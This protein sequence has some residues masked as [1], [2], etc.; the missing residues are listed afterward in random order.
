MKSY[1]E[2]EVKARGV[3]GTYTSNYGGVGLGYEI[4]GVVVVS[5]GNGFY[6]PQAEGFGGL[7]SFVPDDGAGY[8]AK[9][10]GLALPPS[11]KK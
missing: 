5:G 2:S 4:D 11:Y 7:A 6:Y 3:K 8:M 9:V 1:K 10:R